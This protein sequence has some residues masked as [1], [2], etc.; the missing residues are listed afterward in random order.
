[1]RIH[2]QFASGDIELLLLLC[3]GASLVSMWSLMVYLAWLD[4]V[5]RLQLGDE[6]RIPAPVAA[7]PPGGSCLDR[8]W[9]RP[10]GRLRSIAAANPGVRGDGQ[11]S[12]ETTLASRG[13][14]C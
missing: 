5:E 4:P 6:I 3:G 8:F 14:D 7:N 1:M 12:H 10:V 11:L 2:V 13:Q 9:S